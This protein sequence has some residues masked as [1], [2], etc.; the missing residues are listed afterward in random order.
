M[1]KGK[2][3]EEEIPKRLVKI[4][5]ISSEWFNSNTCGCVGLTLKLKLALKCFDFHI[6]TD[7]CGFIDRLQTVH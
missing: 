3:D 5:T 4:N 1:F 2:N 6:Q 7:L